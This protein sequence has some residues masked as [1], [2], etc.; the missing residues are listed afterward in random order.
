MPLGLPPKLA[1]ASEILALRL[2]SSASPSRL[3][4]TKLTMC[5]G[6]VEPAPIGRAFNAAPDRLD[7][8]S[9]PGA[10]AVV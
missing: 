1:I 2:G 9:R 4:T 6:F 10:D 3:A 8:V 5:R 7:E